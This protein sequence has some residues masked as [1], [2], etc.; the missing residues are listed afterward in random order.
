MSGREGTVLAVSEN[1]FGKRT[2]V[3]NYPVQNRGGQGVITMKT[4]KKVGKM[5]A[6]KEVVDKDDLM[7]I[8][9]KGVLIRQPVENISTIGRN[10]QGVK[11]IRLDEGDKIAAVTRV[12]EDD[13]EET[14]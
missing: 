3:L 14:E 2:D 5:V 10:T 11:L 7:I 6:L 13:K 1:G 8:T 12:V 9:Q 4:T